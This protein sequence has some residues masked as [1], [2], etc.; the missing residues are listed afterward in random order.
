MTI[1][2][3]ARAVP[4]VVNEEGIMMVQ[5]TR[6]PVDTIVYAFRQG[7]TA[8][9]IVQSYDTLKLADVYTIIA[10]YLDHQHEIDSYLER[11]EA[12]SKE[13]HQF[14]DVHFDQLGFRERLFARQNV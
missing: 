1:V 10:Y 13:V 2:I 11:R 8:E 12:K 7:A 5:G 6:I 14:I 9:E 4:L 3:E